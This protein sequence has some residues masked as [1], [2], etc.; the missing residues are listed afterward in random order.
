MIKRIILS[1]FEINS[2]NILISEK[3]GKHSQVWLKVIK[4]NLTTSI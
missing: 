3:Y 4:F 2:P 1:Y